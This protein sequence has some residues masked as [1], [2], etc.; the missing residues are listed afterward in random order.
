MLH[1]LNPELLLE[2]HDLYSRVPLALERSKTYPVA[3]ANESHTNTG[4]GSMPKVYWPTLYTTSNCSGEMS[5]TCAGDEALFGLSTY[6]ISSLGAS[7]DEP[8]AELKKTV[9]AQLVCNAIFITPFPAHAL[10]A[11]PVTSHSYQTPE[12]VL[13]D[14]IEEDAVELHCVFGL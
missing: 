7:W 13:I 5:V 10:R 12:A 11:I 9:P 3:S 1:V 14:V 4:R 8:S 6:S 2:S